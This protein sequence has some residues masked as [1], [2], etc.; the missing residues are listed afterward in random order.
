MQRE[1]QETL[2]DL[3]TLFK[4]LAL[5]HLVFSVSPKH[6]K[7]TTDVTESRAEPTTVPCVLNTCWPYC[8]AREPFPVPPPLFRGPSSG[9]PP[10]RLPFTTWACLPLEQAPAPASRPTGSLPGDPGSASRPHVAS[11]V[12]WGVYGWS[13]DMPT[14]L[15]SNSHSRPLPGGGWEGTGGGTAQII[16]C[17]CVLAQSW[18]KSGF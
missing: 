14:G 10:A 17:H 16:P 3:K 4:S 9:P 7:I 18:V 2:K 15:F 6:F 8:S 1:S 13:W 11:S 5:K 12:E